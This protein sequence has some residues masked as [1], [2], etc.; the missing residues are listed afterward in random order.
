MFPDEDFLS[1]LKIE[2]P[3]LKPRPKSPLVPSEPGKAVAFLT[4]TRFSC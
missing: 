2:L 4:S 3:E 1:F